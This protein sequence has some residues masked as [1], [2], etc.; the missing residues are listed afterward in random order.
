[1]SDRPPTP[2]PQGGQRYRT[3]QGS[4]KESSSRP[5]A[6]TPGATG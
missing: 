3:P 4:Q 1:M 2:V 5:Q 6:G